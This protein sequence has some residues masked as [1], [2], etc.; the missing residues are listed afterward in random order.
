MIVLPVVYYN[1]SFHHLFIG[2]LFTINIGII[3]LFHHDG[4]CMSRIE[5]YPVYVVFINQGENRPG[6]KL[7]YLELP[8]IEQFAVVPAPI[9]S[10]GRRSNHQISFIIV[11]LYR[12]VGRHCCAF[13]IYMRN[14]VHNNLNI[15]CMRF[16]YKL[17]K[18]LF[19]AK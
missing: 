2:S 7:P 1:R 18:F 11:T 15:K 6:N 9:P 17:F 13:S 14:Y 16:F 19:A 5:P 3:I 4:H 8:V 12:I 10:I